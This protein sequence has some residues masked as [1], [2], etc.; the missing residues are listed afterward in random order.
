VRKNDLELRENTFADPLHY[1]GTHDGDNED[2]DSV[3]FK[4]DCASQDNADLAE[5]PSVFVD[6]FLCEHSSQNI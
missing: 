1:N 2:T 4:L 6:R 5:L 3:Y